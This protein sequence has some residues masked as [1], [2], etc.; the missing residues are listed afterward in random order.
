MTYDFSLDKKAVFAMI[1]GAIVIGGLLFFAG[2]IVGFHWPSTEPATAANANTG[3]SNKAA[4]PKEPVL[5]EDETAAQAATQKPGAL[6][7]PATAPAGTGAVPLPAT[8]NTTGAGKAGAPPSGTKKSTA[9]PAA[10]PGEQ[11][12]AAEPQTSPADA[13]DQPRVVGGNDAIFTVQVGAFLESEE[14]TRLLKEMERKGYAPRFFA[15]RDAENR[16]WYAVRIGEYA[17]KAQATQAAA[18]FTKQ[19]KIKAVVRPLSAL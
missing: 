1:A 10:A 18:N 15:D 13:S 2:W 19:E 17:D 11:E 12:P 6:T 3:R 5:E 16:Q 14:A 9:P 7:K 4:T 8:G